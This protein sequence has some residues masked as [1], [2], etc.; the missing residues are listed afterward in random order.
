MKRAHL[1]LLG[2]LA[3]LLLL[4][5]KPTLGQELLPGDGQT[6]TGNHAVAIDRCGGTSFFDVFTCLK[7]QPGTIIDQGQ[8]PLNSLGTLDVEIFSLS[9]SSVFPVMDSTMWEEVPQNQEV[10]FLSVARITRLDANHNNVNQLFKG[11]FHFGREY[12]IDSATVSDPTKATVRIDTSR[13]GA[14]VVWNVEVAALDE[15]QYLIV[16]WSTGENPAHKQEFTSPGN[17]VTFEANLKLLTPLLKVLASL[18][19]P[20]PTITTK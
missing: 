16:E 4:A 1:V 10:K 18:D 17:Y 14:D 6:G 11:G 19:L 12:R 15:P 9:L 13:G 20:G 7:S 5:S 8:L 3:V 2:V